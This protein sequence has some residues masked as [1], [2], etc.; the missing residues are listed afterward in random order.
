VRILL[1]GAGGQLG[2]DLTDVL[3]GRV[4]PGGRGG[5]WLGGRSGPGAGIDVVG[6]PHALLDV[7]SRTAVLEAVV[8]LRP[9]VV[10]H[11]AAWT[12]VDA[13]ELDPERAF[14][15]NALGTRHVAEAA[16]RVGAHVVYL[17]TDYVFDGASRR[18]YTE[19][20]PPRPLSAYGRSKLGGEHELDP[21]ATI[22]R[23]S[24]V[25]GARGRNIVRTALELATRGAPLRFV[26]DQRGCPT[27]TADLAEAVALLATERLPGVYHVTNDGDASWFELVAAALT[28]AG[29]DAAQVVA[30]PTSALDPP[31]PA[32]RPAWSVLDHVAWRGLGL[33][34][35]PHWREAL[36]RLVAALPEVN[37]GARARRGAGAARGGARR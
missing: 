16:R 26:D 11:A 3:E 15:V 17:S 34:A 6:A 29:L 33:P 21:D 12:A 23:T 9:D 18:P 27:F 20:D 31:R 32:P 36:E 24:W 22:V 5:R 4:P 8:E 28:I 7:T 2:Q 1:T 19:W 10:V 14:V 37:G 35:L 30:I 25:S 13:C